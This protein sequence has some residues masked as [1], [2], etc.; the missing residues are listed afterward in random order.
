MSEQESLRLCS[1]GWAALNAHDLNQFSKGLAE[2]FQAEVPGVPILL[3]KKQYRDYMQNYL[4][5]FPDIHYDI[6]RTIARDETVVTHWT[7]TGTFTGPMQGP[8]GSVIPPT[9]RKA[10]FKGSLTVENKNGKLTNFYLV[11][12]LAGP[13][14][15][16]GLTPG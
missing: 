7:C 15:Q 16:L 14:Q 9:G 2:D 3:N 12:D 8:D 10:T 13:M 6:T 4:T 1:E 5:A 11:Y